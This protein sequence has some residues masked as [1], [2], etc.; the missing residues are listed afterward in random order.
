MP[1]VTATYLQGSTTNV[2]IKCPLDWDR[3]HLILPGSEVNTTLSISLPLT[4]TTQTIYHF[5]IMMG[6]YNT[7]TR[8]ITYKYI[9]PMPVGGAPT[10]LSL[11]ALVSMGSLP[12]KN[13]SKIQ[14]AG[15]A[16]SYQNN[17]SITVSPTGTYSASSY[18]SGLIIMSTWNWFDS[19]SSYNLWSTS[20]VNPVFANN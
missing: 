15:Q 17:V 18:S 13:A 1:G 8:M 10:Y 14:L 6:I 19:T 3:V 9:E 16:G 4:Y 7:Q 5:E 2:D 20:S 12:L 11:S